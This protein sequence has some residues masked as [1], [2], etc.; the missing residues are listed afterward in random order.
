MSEKKGLDIF[1]IEPVA[2]AIDS[3]VK[4]SLEG[5]QGFLELVCKPALGEV[6]LLAKDQIRFW[7]LNNV[8]RMLEKSK[9][10]LDFESE[11]FQLKANPRI[12]LSIIENSSYIDNEGLLEMWSGLF[13]SSCS[14]SGQDDENLIFIDILKRITSSQAKIIK[15]SVENSKKILYPNGL[16]LAENGLTINAD[17][18]KE[19]T[20]IEN[21][22]RIDRE[23]DSL[24]SMGLYSPLSGGFSVD[25]LDLIAGISPTYLALSLYIRC[26]G[27]N[28]DPDKYWNDIITEDEYNKEMQLKAK[29]EAE[30]RKTQK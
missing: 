28:S 10:K 9:G 15:Y 26:E 1:G 21:I 20:G 25:G 19:L 29:E 12:G 24:R 30:K 13:A 6:G 23:L 2:S 7:R 3:T 18:L 8:I 4:K 22:H 27:S 14:E 16:V 5:I 11:S 17:D